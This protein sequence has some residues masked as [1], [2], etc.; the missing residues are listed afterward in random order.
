MSPSRFPLLSGGGSGSDGGQLITI[1]IPAAPDFA[2]GDAVRLLS[3]LALT[4]ILRRD[5][6]D[7]PINQRRYR[8][9][10]S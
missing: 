7:E 4:V 2:A 5:S 1:I 8:K 3:A 6:C 10:V 9:G